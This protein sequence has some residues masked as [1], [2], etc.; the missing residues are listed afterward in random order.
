M[1]YLNQANYIL[2]ARYSIKNRAGHLRIRQTRQLLITTKHKLLVNNI[3][4][5]LK[6][7][8]NPQQQQWNVYE[9][10]LSKC[11]ILTQ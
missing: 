1:A 6:L 3:S 8:K 2:F 10:L 4:K 5:P 9:A 7:F 11:Y